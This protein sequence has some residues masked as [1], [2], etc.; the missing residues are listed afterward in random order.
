M[1]AEAREGRGLTQ[2]ELAE[3]TGIERTYLTRL[4]A[5]S[6]TIQVERI[7]A[8]LRALEV[9]LTGTQEVPDERPSE[10]R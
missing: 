2:E 9:V 8:V 4:E 6:F 10:I 1:I 7:L 5:P 3:T